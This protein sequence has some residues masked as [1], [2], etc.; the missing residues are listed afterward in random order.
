MPMHLTPIL[1]T[2]R[3]D[4]PPEKDGYPPIDRVG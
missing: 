3:K 4:L 2:P 1:L